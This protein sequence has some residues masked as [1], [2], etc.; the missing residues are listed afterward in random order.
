MGNLSANDIN[1]FVTIR[2]IIPPLQGAAVSAKIRCN[3][4]HDEVWSSSHCIGSS[5][6]SVPYINVLLIVYLFLTGL[7]FDQLKVTI[8]YQLFH[9]K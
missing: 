2:I 1:C 5:R 8:F 9:L 3:E 6:E 4:G 7:H